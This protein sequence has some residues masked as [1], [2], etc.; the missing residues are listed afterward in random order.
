M[1]V[2]VFLSK[3]DISDTFHRCHIR[4]EDVGAFAYVVPPIPSDIEPFL[5]IDLVLPM[6]WV[7]SPDLF[8]ATSETVTDFT[9]IAFHSTRPNRL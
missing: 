9:N 4:P 7:N 2:P 5:W 3:W 8:C 6:G 1:E